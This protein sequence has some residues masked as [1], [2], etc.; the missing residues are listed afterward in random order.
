[1]GKMERIE[2][3]IGNEKYDEALELCKSKDLDYLKQIVTGYINQDKINSVIEKISKPPR[4]YYNRDLQCSIIKR[5]MNAGHIN[6]ALKICQRDIYASDDVVKRK[7]ALIYF[8]MEDYDSALKICNNPAFKKSEKI[9]YIKILILSILK[10][11]D[12]IRTICEDEAFKDS[13][14]IQYPHVELLEEAK[15]YEKALEICLNPRF[16]YVPLFVS[17]EK[18]LKEKITEISNKEALVIKDVNITPL[19]SGCT[20]DTNGLSQSVEK[21]VIPNEQVIDI[22]DI[23]QPSEVIIPSGKSKREYAKKEKNIYAQYENDIIM[24]GKYYLTL[25]INVNVEEILNKLYIADRNNE[26]AKITQEEVEYNKELFLEMTPSAKEIYRELV[27]KK[28]G[29][30]N[31]NYTIRAKRN[32]L[33]LID[34]L[35]DLGEQPLTD[36]ESVDKILNLISTYKKHCGN[37]DKT[38]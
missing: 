8:K 31:Q 38:K 24:L 13:S 33:I 29:P 2:Y 5:L 21:E 6:E 1:M 7:E 4:F 36:Q 14:L 27:Y 12:E 19:V 22:P 11:Y 18:E 30:Y 16:N 23:V 35:K 37:S 28:I 3:F 34:N 9:Q 25:L 10:R 17:K 26:Y 32:L 15:E 20:L